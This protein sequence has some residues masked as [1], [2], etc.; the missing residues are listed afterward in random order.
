MKRIRIPLIVAWGVAV[1]GIIL[2]SFLD[3]QISTAIASSTNGFAL[4]VSAIGPT[5]G[6][7]GVAVMGGGFIALAIKGKYPIGLKILFYVLAA[8]CYGVSIYYSS[9]EYFG[10]NGFYGAAP[11]WVGYLIVAPIEAAAVV[12]GFFLFKDCQNKNMWIVFCIIIG[13]LLIAL[14]GIIPTLK[15]N[16]HRPRYRIL[17]AYDTIQF[18]NWW[19]PCKDYKTIMADNNILESDHFKSYPSGHTA[20]ASILLVMVTFFPLANKKLEKY[21]FPAFLIA[22]GLVLF[23]ALA[24]ILAAA[25]FLSDVSTGATVTLTLVLIANEVVMRIKPLHSDILPPLKEVGASCSMTLT[26]QA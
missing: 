21:Q 6:F 17:S 2:G 8:C 25:H 5:F 20:E 9:G 26:S 18:H 10:I 16:M 3:L 24:R 12:G 4:T 19:E 13:L 7:A 11:K 14:I 23:V 22:C 15:D 1:I